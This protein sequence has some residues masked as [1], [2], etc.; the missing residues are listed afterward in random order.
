MADDI[1][2]TFNISLPK[3]LRERVEQERDREEQVEGY[4]LPRSRFLAKLIHEALERRDTL[5]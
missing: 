3:R 5:K 4:R 1:P 2:K